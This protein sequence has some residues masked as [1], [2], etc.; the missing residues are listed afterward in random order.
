M[1]QLFLCQ[2][3]K[4]IRIYYRNQN[5][6]SK[7]T[8]YGNIYLSKVTTK[9]KNQYLYILLNE[10]FQMVYGL[11]VLSFKNEN[12]RNVHARYHLPKG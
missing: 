9:D 7:K 4:K 10:S 5:H 2:K 11:F 1:Y 12:D 6:Y 3:T 8:T